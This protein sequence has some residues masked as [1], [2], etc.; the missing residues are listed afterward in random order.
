MIDIKEL[1][2]GNIVNYMQAVS[3]GVDYKR[4]VITSLTQNKAIVN[5]IGVKYCNLLPVILDR[6]LIKKIGFDFDD[7]KILSYRYK[8]SSITLDMNESKSE[9]IISY[10]E[11]YK[12]DGKYVIEKVTEII[13]NSLHELQNCYFAITNKELEIKL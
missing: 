3:D 12:E 5:G 2:I 7:K 10:E 13:C 1:R 6:E 11:E 8:D 9:R 4:G